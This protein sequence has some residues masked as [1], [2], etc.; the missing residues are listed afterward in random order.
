MLRMTSSGSNS[1]FQTTLAGLLLTVAAGSLSCDAPESNTDLNPDGPPMVRQVLLTERVQIDGTDRIV[2]GALAFG[3]HAD[4][5]FED[6]DGEVVSAI[7]LGSQEIRVVLDELIR[8]NTLE[9]LACADG[10]FS[11]IPNGTTPDDISDCSGPADSLLNCTKVCLAADGSP[12][13]ILDADEDG[14]VDDMRMI[15][16]NDDPNIVELGVSLECDGEAVP[17]DPDFSFWSPSGN[18][19]FPSNNLLGFRGLGPAI[20]LKPMP[21][22]GIRTSASCGLSFRSEVVD[23]KDN[24]I[25]APDG[26][27]INQDCT[28]GDTVKISFGTEPLKLGISSPADGAVDVRPKAKEF[29]VLGFT[30]NVDPATLGAISLTADG[31]DVPISPTVSEN[32]STSVTIE[33]EP[34]FED[35]TAYVMTIAI[36]LTDALGGAIGQEETVSWTTGSAP[37]MIDAAVP[38]ADLS[39]DADT[40]PDAA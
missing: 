38:D 33:L 22:S 23:Y 8:G 17:L 10:S 5:Y 12:I 29:M 25:C 20:V 27:D 14:A 16:Y 3:T 7:S 11:R 1:L 28:P 37:I 26:G 35:D 13:G 36:G 34:G 21:A 24:Q 6:D 40:T 18:Q 30:A 4:L 31:T 32:D 15:D 9:E 2:E 39:P 19:T